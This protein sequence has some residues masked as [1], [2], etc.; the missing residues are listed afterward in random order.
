MQKSRLFSK[1]KWM[2]KMRFSYSILLIAKPEAQLFVQSKNL[3]SYKK[4]ET[5]THKNDDEE[6][7]AQRSLS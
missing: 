3:N 6:H 2:D 1:T 5:S 7:E 4:D